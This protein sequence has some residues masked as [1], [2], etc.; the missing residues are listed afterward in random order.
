VSS[1]LE[2]DRDRRRAGAVQSRV[3]C[4][5]NHDEVAQTMQPFRDHYNENYPTGYY[6]TIYAKLS[7]DSS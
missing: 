2:R 5:Q 7:I 1:H 6:H 3:R 4:L